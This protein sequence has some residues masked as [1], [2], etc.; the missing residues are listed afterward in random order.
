[1]PTS[2]KISPITSTA[3]AAGTT[4]PTATP[5]DAVATAVRELLGGNFPGPQIP[6]QKAYRLPGLTWVLEQEIEDQRSHFCRDIVSGVPVTWGGLT[7]FGVR[8]MIQLL[9]ALPEGPELET[10]LECYIHA[11]GDSYDAAVKSM[12]EAQAPVE[13]AVAQVTAAYANASTDGTSTRKISWIPFD[14][15]RLLQDPAALEAVGKLI[16]KQT[17]FE[18][19]DLFSVIGLLEP[20]RDQKQIRAFAEFAAERR[21]IVVAT[22]PGESPSQM[23]DALQTGGTL[24]GLSGSETWRRHAVLLYNRYTTR[25]IG[26]LRLDVAPIYVTPVAAFVGRMARLDE[27]ASVARAAAGVKVAFSFPSLGD[28]EVSLEYTIDDYAVA[29]ALQPLNPLLE[30]GGQF[31]SWG[32]ATLSTNDG[33]RQYPVVR[34]EQWVRRVLTDFLL[35]ETFKP[36]DGRPGAQAMT[37]AIDKF[38]M[39]HVGQNDD[40]KAFSSAIVTKVAPNTTLGPHVYDIEAQIGFKTTIT[41]FA[42]HV[43]MQAD[44]QAEDV[45]VQDA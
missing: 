45:K 35:K 18:Q 14:A 30:V 7:L 40:T 9:E 21:A 23:I 37:A 32:V 24:G 5:S 11:L 28:G 36:A 33:D 42:V 13:R 16:P 22:L 4:S 38:L 31:V 26:E 27:E 34:T 3:A 12:L 41:H 17:H 15:K 29:D 20:L 44:Y 39:K 2:L 43:R 1:M 19:G 6:G 10:A 25:K 8:A